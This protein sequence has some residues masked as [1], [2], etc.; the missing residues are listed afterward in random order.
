MKDKLNG[1]Y[2]VKWKSDVFGDARHESL[3]TYSETACL[4]HRFTTTCEMIVNH[5]ALMGRVATVEEMEV[6]NGVI[7]MERWPNDLT[8]IKMHWVWIEKED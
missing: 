2:R 5:I 7:I 3:F 4:M 1:N 6:D 8:L